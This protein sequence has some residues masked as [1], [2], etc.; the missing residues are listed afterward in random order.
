MC[1][2]GTRN[3]IP[4]F[5]IDLKSN[6]TNKEIYKIEFLLNTRIKFEAPHKK[7][8]PQC[9]KCQRFGHTKN[10][11]KRRPRCVKCASLHL[12]SD[13]PMKEKSQNVKCVNCEGNH[14]ANYR[15][16]KI[17]KELQKAK[18]PSL[19]RKELPV[20]TGPTPSTLH[21]QPPIFQDSI[22]HVFSTNEW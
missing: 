1:K 5:Y 12:T 2:R 18:Y 10:L 7:R 4:M 13:C 6:S 17:Y 15:G 3:P 19:R 8:E 22:L 21:S 9:M 20:T 16:C 11:C 14:P